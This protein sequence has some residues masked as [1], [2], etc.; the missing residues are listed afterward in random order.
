MVGQNDRLSPEEAALARVKSD[1][2]QNEPQW[3]MGQAERYSKF[4]PLEEILKRE[5]SREPMGMSCRAGLCSFW[6]DWQGKMI[7]C[8]MYGSVQLDTENRTFIDCWKELVEQTAQ[9][10][11]APY[12]TGCPN[13]GLC[14]PCIAMV[15]NECGDLNGRPDYI[16]KMNEAQARFYQEYARKYYPDM[17][18]PGAA[19]VPSDI[20]EL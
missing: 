18:F 14:H 20:C 3:F 4:V 6:I 15:S 7:N 8:G 13:R 12:C 2:Y 9:V 1:Y 19:P 5:P 10:R 11:F 17:P 16:C